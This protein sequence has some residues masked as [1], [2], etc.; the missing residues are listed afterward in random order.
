MPRKSSIFEDVMQLTARLPWQYGLALATFFGVALHALASH[1]VL[2]DPKAAAQVGTVISRQLI[3]AVASILQWV[4]PTACLIGAGVSALQRRRGIVLFGQVRTEGS[5]ALSAM[6][7]REFEA[8]IAEA[9]RQQGFTVAEN[10]TGGADGGVD[11]VLRRDSRLYLVQCKHWRRSSVG[12]AVVREL[13]GVVTA[14]GAK[15]G[16]VVTSGTFTIEAR[17]FAAQC[18]LQLIDG[19]ALQ[20]MVSGVGRS[21]ND[22]ASIGRG[23]RQCPTCGRDMALRTARRGFAAGKQFW[24]CERFPQCRGTAEVS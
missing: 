4:L 15:G 13:Y 21:S 16:F 6:S 18:K 1:L 11:L 10:P 7:W 14:R 23:A 22:S 20:T 12:V 9:F 17:S 8:L 19:A 5:A 24:G 2:D 3:A